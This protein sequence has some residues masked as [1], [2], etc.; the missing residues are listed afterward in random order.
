[1]LRLRVYTMVYALYECTANICIYGVYTN[2]II[3]TYLMYTSYMC[4]YAQES[5]PWPCVW[6]ATM[7]TPRSLLCGCPLTPRS[8]SYPTRRSPT[9]LGMYSVYMIV[10]ML[11]KR[12]STSILQCRRDTYTTQCIA[13]I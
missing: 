10:F 5:R 8:T 4:V 1:M 7:T 12:T 3:P 2:N 13:Y 9:I 11:T 6:T